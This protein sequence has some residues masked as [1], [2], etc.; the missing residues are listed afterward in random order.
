M[1][2]ILRW[3]FGIT[4][5]IDR[6]QA[7]RIAKDYCEKHG[8]PWLEPIWMRLNFRQ[9]EVMTYADHL[10]GNIFL[11]VDCETGAVTSSG[12]TPR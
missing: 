2:G 3:I 10:G 1:M 6:E 12:P 9:Y 5:R 8:W 11:S 4:V 7:V